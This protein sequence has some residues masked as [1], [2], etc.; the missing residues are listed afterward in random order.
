[1]RDFFMKTATVIVGIVA[2]SLTARA[3]FSYTTTTKSAA[4]MMG[5]IAGAGDRT[6]KHFF[7]GSKMKMDLGET[8]T[9]LDFDAQTI[10]HVDNGKKSYTVTSFDEVSSKMGAGLSKSG[11]QISVDVKETG[12]KKNVNGYDA[13]EVVMSMDMDSPQARQTG[14]KMRM[15]MDMWLSPA[16][17]GAAEVRAF[18]QKN[19]SRFPWGAMFGSRG[20]PGM[21]KG[22]AELQRKM[23]A[24]NGVPVLQVMRL[25]TVGNE[26]Q[27]AQAQKQMAQACV[28]FE[29]MKQKGGQQAATAEQMMKRLNC[30][31]SG[32]GG[33]TAFEVT[34]ESS[35]FSANAIPESTFAVPA[36][37]KQ[38]EK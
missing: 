33:A 10:T 25:K 26:A 15:E 21:Q 19:G 1:M 3:D 35:N 28:Q 16:V 29:Q 32:G 11:A 20:D 8:A 37:Y 2:A 7:K 23:A 9:I 5:G 24:M 14:M 18:Y 34:I 22:I 38:T 30:G 4:G 36:G 13:H 6:T 17:P 27:M 12:Q 31:A